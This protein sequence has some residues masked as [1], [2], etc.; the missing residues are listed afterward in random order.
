M[1]CHCPEG[2]DC[3]EGRT[4]ENRNLLNFNFE[5]QKTIS[6]PPKIRNPVGFRF[7]LLENFVLDIAGILLHNFYH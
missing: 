5:T 2:A 3:V 6:M 7:P 1:R 4:S